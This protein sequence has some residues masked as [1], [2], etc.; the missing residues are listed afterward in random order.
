MQN[1]PQV[2]LAAEWPEFRLFTNQPSMHG[3]G[4]L[5]LIAPRQ[6]D[7]AGSGLVTSPFHRHA[8]FE[9]SR[10]RV[11]DGAKATFQIFL[12]QNF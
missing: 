12:G 1:Q 8:N 2:P 9:L 3:A 11:I 6:L 5:N 7:F 10:A 4:N